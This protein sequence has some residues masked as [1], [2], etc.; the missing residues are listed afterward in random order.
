MPIISKSLQ[1]LEVAG[2]TV[3]PLVLASILTLALILEQ[4]WYSF[5][6]FRRLK[7]LYLAPSNIT[8]ISGMDM[9]S[10]MARWL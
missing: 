6:S 10:R 4:F 8:E 3:L 1:V 7:K 2:W 9:V 5:L